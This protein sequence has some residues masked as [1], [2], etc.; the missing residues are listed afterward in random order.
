[1][2]SITKVEIVNINNDLTED[3]V[4]KM[5]TLINEN[6]YK[7]AI[8]GNFHKIWEECYYYGE[9]GGGDNYGTSY[10]NENGEK[11][12]V[13]YYNCKETEYVV[14]VKFNSKFQKNNTYSQYIELLK[15]TKQTTIGARE[16]TKE[17]M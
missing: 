9:I 8:V 15:T 3:I 7:L 2:A 10:E 17:Q 16:A 6:I 12:S 14:C 4:E 1:M 11:F 13:I 5:E